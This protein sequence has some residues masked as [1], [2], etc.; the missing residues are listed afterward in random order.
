MTEEEKSEEIE[1]F[2][3]DVDFETYKKEAY[4]LHIGNQDDVLRRVAKK[5][6]ILAFNQ[7]KKRQANKHYVRVS[8][9]VAKIYAKLQFKV[10]TKAR[11]ELNRVA[12]ALICNDSGSLDEKV[13]QVDKDYDNWVKENGKKIDE[14]V[15]EK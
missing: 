5:T 6:I 15:E 13:N 1:V 11:R 14:E 10:G 4:D 7:G 8:K 9:E 3:S 12:S 2:V